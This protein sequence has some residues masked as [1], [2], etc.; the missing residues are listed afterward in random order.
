[1]S[2]VLLVYSETRS[3]NNPRLHGRQNWIIDRLA[4]KVRRITILKGV[5]LDIL[6]DGT[7]DLIGIFTT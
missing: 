7:L 1:M 3:F 4:N 6:E 5:E 2:C